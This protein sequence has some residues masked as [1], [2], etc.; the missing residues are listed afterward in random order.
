MKGLLIKDLKTIFGIQKTTIVFLIA[1][2]IWFGFMG[3]M[4]M[5]MGYMVFLAV[6]ISISTISYDDFNNGTAFL[7]TLPFER[8]EYV[9]EKYLLGIFMGTIGALIGFLVDIVRG[10]ATQGSL[11]WKDSLMIVLAVLAV[12]ILMLAV[13]L[14]VQLKFGAEKGRLISMLVYGVIGV[15]STFLL[16]SAQEN[17]IN[18]KGLFAWLKGNE[19]I[20]AVAAG[21][22]YLALVAASWLLSI[23]IVEKKEL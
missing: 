8:K 17:A 7:F 23:K 12:G 2:E 15:L 4:Q 11:E 6:F 22:V 19:A 20:A 3:M 10:V 18:W 1:F 13:A 14:P 9:A 21:A 5:A 16:I